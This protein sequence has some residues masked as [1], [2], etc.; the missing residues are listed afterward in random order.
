MYNFYKLWCATVEIT[1]RTQMAS[2]RID[3]QRT[4]TLAFLIGDE[5]QARANDRK[6][7]WHGAAA[8]PRADGC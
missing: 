7:A 1:Q 5:Q 8:R 4:D 6:M 3:V 2:V